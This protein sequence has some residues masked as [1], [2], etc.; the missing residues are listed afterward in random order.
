M[1]AEPVAAYGEPT[2]YAMPSKSV[3]AKERVMASTVS[4][5]DYF[6]ELI[7]LVHKDYADL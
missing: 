2:T 7:T 3:S 6:D 5:D 4:V 1:A